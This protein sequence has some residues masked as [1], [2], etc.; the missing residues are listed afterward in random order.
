MNLKSSNL[1]YFKSGSGPLLVYVPGMEGSGRLFYK[2]EPSLAE[3]YTVVALP[4]RFN[5]PF[6]YEDL[7]GDVLNVLLQE[8]AEKATIVGESF[9]GTVALQFALAHQD[10]VERLVL[11]NTF[12]YFRERM[13]LILG[14]LLLPLTFIKLGNAVRE[15]FYRTAM[16]FEGIAKEDV[17]RLL[18]SSFI[19]GYATSRQRMQLIRNLDVRERLA[20]IKIPV[21]IIAAGQDKLV[22]SI[23]E[24]RFMASIMPNAHVIE[25]PRHGHTPLISKDF[26]LS[27]VL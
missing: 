12:P 14:L 27:D 4:S 3:K 26:L 18:Q 23:K 15:F 16:G 5:S 2:Q 24:A 7:V 22:P 10:R 1:Q 9:G 8:Q 25:L 13:R 20:E 19:H 6:T 21:T 17:N 11:V